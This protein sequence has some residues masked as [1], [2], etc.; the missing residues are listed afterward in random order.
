MKLWG[1]ARDEPRIG[2]MARDSAGLN[3]MA[4]SDFGGIYSTVS[5]YSYVA[6]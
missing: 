1:M 2:L 4:R 6:I 3:G 5:R